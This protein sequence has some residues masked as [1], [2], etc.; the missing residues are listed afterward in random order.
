MAAFTIAIK[1]ATVR[2]CLLLS[3]LICGDAHTAASQTHGTIQKDES[4]STR[5]NIRDGMTHV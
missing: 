3:S 4:G 5:V 2:D 1:L